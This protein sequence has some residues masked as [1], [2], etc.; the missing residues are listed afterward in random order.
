MSLQRYH[1][2]FLN[3]LEVLEEV[4]GKIADDELAIVVAQENRRKNGVPT[5]EDWAEPRERILALWFIRGANARNNAEY[6][7]H[8]HNSSWMATITIP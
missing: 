6:L 4:G 1:E 8:L 7:A 5:S 2:L 3:Q